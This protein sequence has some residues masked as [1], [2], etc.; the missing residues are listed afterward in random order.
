MGRYRG[1]S[2]ITWC[3]ACLKIL[4]RTMHAYFHIRTVIITQPISITHS[5]VCL[6][7]CAWIRVITKLPNSEQSYKWKVKTH[8]YINRQNQST[9]GKLWKRNDPDL[10]QAFLKKWWAEVNFVLFNSMLNYVINRLM[11]A[12]FHIRTVIILRPISTPG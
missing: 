11:H 4:S 1:K 2:L 10:V 9:T 3:Q 8:K 12:L 6:G 5:L 7:G